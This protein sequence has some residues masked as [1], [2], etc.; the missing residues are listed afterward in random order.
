[1][2]GA[3]CAISSWLLPTVCSPAAAVT[4]SGR[5]DCSESLSLRVRLTQWQR[6]WQARSDKVLRSTLSLRLDRV[7]HLGPGYPKRN[8]RA[9]PEFT[10]KFQGG[11]GRARPRA[12]RRGP[13]RAR[14]IAE[15]A[16]GS[17]GWAGG[18][19]RPSAASGL[20]T[21]SQLGLKMATLGL[22]LHFRFNLKTVTAKFKVEG[23]RRGSGPARRPAG[24]YTVASRAPQPRRY[25]DRFK[26]R[27]RVTGSAPAR[28][29][30]Y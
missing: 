18:L 25:P 12:R 21:R 11:L 7:F 4:G 29:G 3:E 28:P 9:A 10:F 6:Q 24:A 15:L 20:S 2:I 8:Q 14:R 1:V 17:G 22:G 27:F 23:D 19:P 30:V 26:S 13:A 16:A 5:A